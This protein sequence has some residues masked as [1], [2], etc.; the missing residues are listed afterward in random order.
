MLEIFD[1]GH[2]VTQLLGGQVNNLHNV[3]TMSSGLH[4]L[5]GAFVFWLEPVRG[6]VSH[7][8]IL[9][10]SSSLNLVNP[11]KYL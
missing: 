6:Q 10:L 7:I 9:V 8:S 3:I 1:L 4:M 5:F 2:V 11:D